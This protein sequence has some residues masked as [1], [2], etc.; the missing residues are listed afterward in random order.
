MS[1]CEPQVEAHVQEWVRRVRAEYV[2]MPGMT[3]TRRQISRLW[4][5]DPSLCDAV[6]DSLVR[7]GFLHR[8]PDDTYARV[9]AAA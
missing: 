9:T 3:L 4:L 6:V 1:V 7:S 5:L 2:E 8:R